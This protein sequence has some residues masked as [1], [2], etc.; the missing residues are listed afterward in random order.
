[1]GPRH[2]SPCSWVGLLAAGGGR[3]YLGKAGSFVFS[4]KVFSYT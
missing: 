4:K 2:R 1:M 3:G